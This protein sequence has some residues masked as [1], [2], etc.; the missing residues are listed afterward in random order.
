M[1]G[2]MQDVP[3]NIPMIARHAERLHGKKVVATNTDHGVRTATFREVMGRARRL[4]TALRSLGV[5]P[6]DRVA[7]FCWNHQQHLEAYTAVPCMGAILHTLNIR[8]FPADVA[9]IV[10]HAQDKVVIVD[11]SLLPLWEKVAPSVRCVERLI[12]VADVPG[13]LPPGALDYEDLV[14]AA[15][16]VPDFPDVPED[17]AAALCYTSGTTGHPKGVLYSHRSNVLHTYATLLGDGMGVRETDVVLAIVPMFHANAWG[18]PYS[19]LMVGAEITMPGRHMTPDALTALMV[20]RKVTLGAGVP[21]IWQGMLEPM[22]KA[23]DGL[24]HLRALVCGG[25]AVPPALQKAYRREMGVRMCHAWGMT[26]TSPLGSI[27]H[28]LAAH[29]GIDADALDL[30]LTSQGRV[31]PGIEI[32]LVGEDGSEQPWDGRS[33]GEIQVRGN[34]VASAYYRDEGSAARFADGWFRTGDVATLDEDG[35]IRIV[36]R[37]KDLIKSGGEWISSVALEGAI[38][39]HPDVAE[40][41]VIAVAHPH[42]AERPLACVVPRPEARE[43]LTREAVLDHLR[44]RVASWWLP[45]DVVFLDQVPKTSVGKFDKKALRERFRDHVLPDA[46]HART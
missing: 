30:V 42:W 28:P 33:V 37:T 18:L 31:A 21:T 24:G 17:Q 9:Y 22:K 39:A 5:G 23:K 1:K 27:C 44:P 25:S 35:Y 3:L 7:T 34:W 40:A 20:E 6:D 38:M 14:A 45:D 41:A 10:E 29:E 15:E 2:L 26:E 36:D 13:P 46:P 4:V 43:R 32:R 16:P 19:C 12:V 11:R 8:L